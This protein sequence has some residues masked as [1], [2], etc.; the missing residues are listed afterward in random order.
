[1]KELVKLEEI[2][3]N[4]VVL[5]FSSDWCSD[6]IKLKM[7]I[8]EIIDKYKN[9]QFYYVERDKFIELAKFYNIYGIPSFVALKDGELV[10]DLISKEEKNY[11]QV[12]EFMIQLERV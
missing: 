3:Q 6:C 7:F 2:E 11:Q 4:Q 9:W 1:M 8:D 12:D 10:A 5:I